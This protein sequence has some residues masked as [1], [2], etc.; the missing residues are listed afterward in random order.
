MAAAFQ[1]PVWHRTKR[2]SASPL[3]LLLVRPD[4][5]PIT[6][7]C[8]PAEPVQIHS[9]RGCILGQLCMACEQI[10]SASKACASASGSFHF[11]LPA[12]VLL[13]S[14]HPYCFPSQVSRS[15]SNQARRRGGG[16]WGGPVCEGTIHAVLDRFHSRTH[17]TSSSSPLPPSPLPTPGLHPFVQ[18]LM[19]VQGSMRGSACTQLPAKNNSYAFIDF[20]VWSRCRSG[21]VYAILVMITVCYCYCSKLVPMALGLSPVLLEHSLDYL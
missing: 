14:F 19:C 7:S 4:A 5:K 12:H 15:Q 1:D 9:A 20:L 6:P 13:C 21:Q 11:P 18:G 17:P 3:V 10:A 16:G 8:G 2:S